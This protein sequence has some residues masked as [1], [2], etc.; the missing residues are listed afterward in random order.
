MSKVQELKSIIISPILATSNKYRFQSTRKNNV[1]IVKVN[2]LLIEE[3]KER[4]SIKEKCKEVSEIY[5]LEEDEESEIIAQ[6]EVVTR[7]WVYVEV[8]EMEDA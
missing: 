2:S 1:I 7:N 5:N 8:Y 6:G 3:C 4:V